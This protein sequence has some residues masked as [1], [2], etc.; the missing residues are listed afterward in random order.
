M[1]L[2]LFARLLIGLATFTFFVATSIS[3]ED[4]PLPQFTNVTQQAGISFNHCLGSKKINNIVEA[5]GS[6]A[7]WLDYDQDGWMDLYLVNGCY[8]EGVNDPK[9]PFKGK[10]VTDRL[11]RNKHDGTFEDVT[12]KAGLGGPED[13]YGMAV[14]VADYDND[15]YPDLYVT[16]YGGNVLYHNNGNG[17]FT[18]VTA[19]AGVACKGEWSTGAVFFDYDKDGELDLFVGGYL[20]YDAVYRLFYEADIYPGPLAYPAMKSHLFHNNGDGT[21]TEVTQKA[22][23]D[24]EGR[25]MGALAV[26]Y[27]NDGW[28]DLFVANDATPNYLYHNNH[29]GTF[30]DM[31]L[32]AA[33]GFGQNGNAAA[34][35]GGDWR[36]Y[37]HDGRLDLLVPA[38]GYNALFHNEGKG[39]FEDVAVEAGLAIITAQYW[40][41]GGKFIDYDNDGFVDV[42]V[43]NGDGHRLSEI[44][45][46]ILARN[47]PGLG[48]KRVF[49]D[50]AKTS[51]EVLD[52]KIVARGLALADFDNDGDMDAAILSISGPSLLLRNDGGN[53]N[54]WLQLQ[55]QGTKSNRDGLGAKVIV[56]AGELVQFDEMKNGTSYLSAHDPRMH[57]GLGTHTKVDEVII[58]WP[59]GILQT[60]TNIKAN[61]LLKA[62]EP[63]R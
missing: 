41:W 31:A 52:D 24:K 54:N 39:L 45:E 13:G 46:M 11:Y 30:S 59:S 29:D 22:K 33:V 18:D 55:L 26:D 51:G 36:D 20:K 37:D 7:G 6:G 53:R 21:F 15:G 47:V 12:E 16:N 4:T 34:N 5:T 25:A 60:F 38:M 9:S 27:D 14:Q 43:V 49:K 8:L 19:K 23:V 1:R 10:K 42:M 57:F 32:N 63:R 50:V 44:Q 62:V 56:K 17:T 28:V 2:M 61:Q 40:S 35:M 58:K 3:N 48:G